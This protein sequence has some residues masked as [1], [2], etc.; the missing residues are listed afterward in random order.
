MAGAAAR[1]GR[2][3]VGGGGG[4]APV[5]PARAGGGGGGGGGGR[6]AGS[7]AAPSP[8]RTLRLV[9]GRMTGWGQEGPWA[10]RA[11]HDI[12][13]LAVTGVLHAI[14]PPEAPVPPLNLVADY[15]G[16]GGGA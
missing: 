8:T 10:D 9:Y 1:G 13:Y 14:G 5:P 4:G 6:P 7:C 12:D 3:G 15:G 16:G 2:G 11:G